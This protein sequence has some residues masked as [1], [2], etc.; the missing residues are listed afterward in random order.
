MVCRPTFSSIVQIVDKDDNKISPN[1]IG[2][3][4]TWNQIPPESTIKYE[5]TTYPE[6]EDTT[7]LSNAT[8]QSDKIS[9]QIWRTNG[10]YL[11]QVS[12]R[13]Y[14][15]SSREDKQIYNDEMLA[16]LNGEAE[17]MPIFENKV[18]QEIDYDRTISQVYSKNLTT[19]SEGKKKGTYKIPKSANWGSYTFI[20]N[21]GYDD[22]AGYIGE[23]ERLK[24][25][26][27]QIIRQTIV[28][29]VVVALLLAVIFITV[30]PLA[31]SGATMGATALGLG[32]KATL[33]AQA[34]AIG[35]AIYLEGLAFN[36]LTDYVITNTNILPS[37]M[38]WTTIKSIQN[39]GENKYGCEFI[40]E[41]G[42]KLEPVIH[43]Y[44]AVVCPYFY[45]DKLTNKLTL[46][47]TP[48][49]DQSD[50]NAQMT[51]DLVKQQEQ[52]YMVGGILAFAI[53]TSMITK[54][55]EE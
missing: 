51:K 10:E 38:E 45:I 1:V 24:K 17:G 39:I 11:E 47:N 32:A 4:N 52:L 48:P 55:G 46:I 14:S 44:G 23:G 25:V 20:F 40:G 53:I 6:W 9:F 35:G 19:D 37:I 21:Y 3:V 54:G 22:N 50:I 18:M 29:V 12:D 16:F 7:P 27:E 33:V 36:A 43:T 13:V 15:R 30:I 49:P 42:S 41:S 8:P 26:Q 5:L 28:S 2:E 31:I 34:G